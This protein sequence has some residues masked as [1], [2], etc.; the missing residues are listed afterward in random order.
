[1]HNKNLL[2]ILLNLLAFQSQII[3]GQLVYNDIPAT[4]KSVTFS[5]HFENNSN[6]WITYNQWLSG[7]IANNQYQ[8]KCKNYHNLIGI[9]YKVFHNI[10][11]KDFE[12]EASI[13]IIKGNGG[14]V[15]GMTQDFRHYRIELNDEN[16]LMLFRN[17]P[18][19]KKLEKLYETALSEGV[20][21]DSFCKITVRKFNSTFYLYLNEVSLGA[22]N[23]INLEGEP[24][25]IL[26]W[27]EIGD[28]G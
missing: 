1:M 10:I 23:N 12:I 25:R 7:K 2:F 22:Y 4:R 14:L 19:G 5:E 17:D 21:A 27:T 13:R 28:L 26:C 8:I 24:D 6:H 9:S 11:E 15:F 20:R 16:M 3:F 18:S